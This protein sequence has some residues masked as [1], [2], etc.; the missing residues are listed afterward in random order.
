MDDIVDDVRGVVVGGCMRGL[1]AATLIDGHVDHHRAW[2]HGFDHIGGDQLRRGGSR[3]EHPADDQIRLQNVFLDGK[4]GGVHGIQ[5]AAELAPQ[6]SQHVGRAVDDPGVGAHAH[7]DVRRMGTD[8]TAAD[9]DDFR[10]V[11]AGHAAEQDPLAALHLLQAV[12]AG[13]H[14]ET[15]GHFG[16]GRQQRQ[17]AEGG[18][19]G[20][21]GD[22]DCAA[23]HQILGLLGIRGQVQ[24]GEQNLIR[25]QHGPL[26]RLWLLHL[27][28]HFRL[29]EDLRGVGGDGRS[30]A[31]VVVV[32]GADAGAG[33][34]FH[35]GLV[36]VVG[37][38]T[39]ALRRH[40]DT[41]FV[42]L[43]LCGYTNQHDDSSQ[44]FRSS[45]G[46]GRRPCG[47]RARPCNPIT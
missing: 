44:V 21:V 6:R 4:A 13:L 5:R 11:H 25:L 10:R 14:G 29:V 26:V 33:I 8:H 38:F 17:A 16:H 12:G 19:H 36:A 18:C 15:P 35:Q 46:F 47:Y 45:E 39:N 24:V 41:V 34:A 20:L 43:N 37:D 42:V 30:G 27:D 31:L 40:A 28:D 9:N 22:A 7:G 1:E 23:C 3:D 2:L 32:A